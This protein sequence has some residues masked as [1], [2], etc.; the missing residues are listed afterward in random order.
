MHPIYVDANEWDNDW[1][2]QGIVKAVFRVLDRVHAKGPRSTKL[3]AAATAL[4]QE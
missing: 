1:E 3:H 2:V 4:E